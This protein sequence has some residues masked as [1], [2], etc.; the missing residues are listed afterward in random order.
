MF[1]IA[2]YQGTH[3]L[4]FTSLLL[5]KGMIVS[6]KQRM[7]PMQV[8]WNRR[9][10]VRHHYSLTSIITLGSYSKYKDLLVES[11]LKGYTLK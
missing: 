3:L 7:L 10:A 6:D 2:H 5:G 11:T 8:V 1:H 9:K 4:L